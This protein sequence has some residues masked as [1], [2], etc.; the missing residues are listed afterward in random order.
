[1]AKGWNYLIP[2]KTKRDPENS[3]QKLLMSLIDHSGLVCLKSFD[4]KHMRCNILTV[5]TGILQSYGVSRS[6]PKRCMGKE[7]CFTETCAYVLLRDKNEYLANCRIRF[8]GGASVALRGGC[9]LW[10]L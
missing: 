8:P 7:T 5:F 6:A 10:G 3:N 2:L 9:D 1:M 4:K